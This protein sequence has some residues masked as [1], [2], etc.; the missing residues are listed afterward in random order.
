MNRILKLMAVALTWWTAVTVYANTTETVSQVTAAVSLD[1][2]VDYVITSATPFT[3]AGKVDMVSP[4]AALILKKVKP[5]AAA[6]LLSHITINGQ[7]AVKGSNCMLKIYADGTIILP[8]GT[9]V[10]P[11]TV[12]TEADLQ[13]ESAQFAVGNRLSLKNNALNNR[14]KSFT[15]MRGYMVCLAT[16]ADGKGYS[17]LF[18]ADREDITVNLPA[19]L[20]GKVS[21]LRVQQWND[22][23]KK[24]YAGYD[25]AIN[26]P[27]NTTWCYNWDA[28][29]NIWDDREYVTQHHHEGWPGI[30]DVGNNG[31]SACI[32][33]N[34][35]PDNTGDAREQV[36]TVD[37][38]LA[39]WPEMM[40]TGRRLGSPAMSGNMNWLYAFI[41]SIDAR[42]WR[43]DFV[44]MHCYWYSDWPSW[45]ATLRNV[46]NRTKRP[47]WITEMNYGANWTGWPGADTSGSAANFNIERQHLGPVVD[48]L[49]ET[50][51]L[52]RYAVYNWVQ[53]C[54]SVYLNGKLT[55][56]GEYYAQK[57]SN[58]AYN[59]QYEVVPNMP[60]QYGPDNLKA[61]YDKNTGATLLT[62]HDYNGEY[63]R[64]MKLER[65]A[66]NGKWEEVADIELQEDEADY[67]Y[68]DE[69]S[70]FGTEFRIHIVDAPG[71]GRYSNTAASAITSVEPGDALTV[72]G[73]K[74]YVGGNLFVNGDFNLGL[75]GWTNGKGEA[76]DAPWFEAVPRGGIDDG[77][78]L[79][80]WGNGDTGDEQSIRC[81]FD[82]KTDTYY[83]ATI[84]CSGIDGKTQRLTMTQNPK[85]ES[86]AVLMLAATRDWNVQSAVV[87]SG[88]Y[89]LAMLQLRKLGS[90]A[91]FDNITLCQLF[92]TREE[93][94]ADARE[95]ALLRI[96]AAKTWNKRYPELNHW[97][98]A[99]A[100]DKGNDALQLA[101]AIDS[102]RHAVAALDSLGWLLV[103][104]EQLMAE[105]AWFAPD[106]N[107]A[108]PLTL[109]TTPEEAMQ[110]LKAL[111]ADMQLYHP[112]T[113][114][115]DLVQSYN[116]SAVN[117]WQTATGTYK[118]GDQR[119][120]TVAGR[121]CWNAWWSG[122]SADEGEAQSMAIQQDITGAAHGYYQLECKAATQHY[123]LTDQHG[124]IANGDL[125]QPTPT[126]S[127]ALLDVP[128]VANADK[129]QTLTS[130]ALYFADEDT[131]TIGFTSSKAG[132]TDY[133]WR[134]YGN[135]QSNGDRREGWWCA[136][137]FVLHHRPFYRRTLAET[138]Q[139]EP[140]AAGNDL[141][142]W[143]AVCLPYAIEHA[144]DVTLYQIVGATS[145]LTRL[146]L[147]PVETTEAGMP[148]IFCTQNNV[149]NL[150][151]TGKP[152]TSALTT[153]QN[154]RG[155]FKTSSK[156]PLKSYVLRDGE[157]YRINTNDD[158]TPMQNYSAVIRNA[159]QLTII[160]DWQ[161]VTMPIHGLEE[162]LSA[163][164]SVTRDTAPARHYDLHGRP[165]TSTTPGIIIKVKDGK[166][167]KEI[168]R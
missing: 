106:N 67:T 34:N 51:W 150:A 61:F 36:N 37:E 30:V 115:R 63:N 146:C 14:I 119:R 111:Q 132:T 108:L 89:P 50:P 40:A 78:Y 19:I 53:D 128:T 152:V 131:I 87:N 21:S 104:K 68:S 124:F 158:R 109:P 94:M 90:T 46:Y 74:R 45:L 2:D 159:S 98:D 130:G 5:S 54:R 41:D 125:V 102:V 71:K 112:A 85:L 168:R 12:Y 52:E 138:A 3:T 153:D 123:C 88:V 147:E 164:S 114:K 101:L 157:W 140:P 75:T 142:F 8:H 96:E 165:A 116:F 1:T 139:P 154:L 62:W 9:D 13:G 133:I 79:Q 134:E 39:T 126:L 57:E 110:Q 55:P 144:S 15:L 151:E 117:G 156:A 143:G 72:D 80:A 93:A 26:E 24:G 17:R 86:Q 113:A 58:I 16:K 31:T 141:V 77:A 100:A 82:I 44:V 166:A 162:D 99:Q 149:L 129:W 81:V 32:L 35:E 29:I 136:T 160:S 161:G 48:G 122:I 121:T 118:G 163:I 10:K 49:E 64:S 38:V 11:L 95:K 18:I 22:A 76:A 155:N 28:G 84:A 127:L 69:T 107:D 103:M 65:K 20:S 97:L 73:Q 60:R 66:Q 91:Q 59:S 105:G 120:N 33:G 56:M 145:D 25:P 83:F 167:K 23:S 137:D 27:L 92:D 6:N 43:C 148:Y 70:P 4:N 47:I 7:R 135:P 42:G